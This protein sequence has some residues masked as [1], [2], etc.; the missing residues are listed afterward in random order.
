MLYK[1]NIECDNIL[2]TNSISEL[3]QMP[4]NVTNDETP[5]SFNQEKP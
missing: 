1:E 5:R 4:S 3:C 2:E